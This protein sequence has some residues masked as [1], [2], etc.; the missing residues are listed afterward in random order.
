MVEGPTVDMTTEDVQTVVIQ[1]Y[2]VRVTQAE[3]PV[4]VIQ[5]V[6]QVQVTREVDQDLAMAEVDQEEDTRTVVDI[7]VVAQTVD[8]QTVDLVE[9]ILTTGRAM[10]IR[11][12]ADQ[13]AVDLEG[14]TRAATDPEV[15]LTEA[16]L[17][18]DTVDRHLHI[19]TRTTTH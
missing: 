8:I 16:G 11:E 18:V 7:Q 3:D 12:E 6:G 13:V 10:D 2:Q 17:K 15:T 14:Y 1:V 9:D 4:Q 5:E 19:G